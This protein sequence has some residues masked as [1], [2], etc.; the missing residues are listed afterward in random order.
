MSVPLIPIVRFQLL[1]IYLISLSTIGLYIGK[2]SPQLH[3]VS[4]PYANIDW[5]IVE[6]HKGNF[7]THS[8]G[9][10]I[11]EDGSIIY[12]NGEIIDADGNQVRGPVS[13]HVHE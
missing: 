12:A 11:L 7:H 5:D 6:H 8:V 9:H 2:A 3:V 10:K 4:N 1:L 13:G